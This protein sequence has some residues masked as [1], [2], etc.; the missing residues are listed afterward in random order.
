MIFSLSER[1]QAPHYLQK[2]SVSR[3]PWHAVTTS[4][5]FGFVA[6]ILE[7]LFPG[8]I[9]PALFQL[10]GS[11]ALVVWGTALVSQIVLRR[12]ADKAGVVLPVR[13]SGFPGL[14]IFALAILAAIFAVGFSAEQSRIQLIS[15][16]AV[17]AAIAGASTLFRKAR[18]RRPHP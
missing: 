7:L 14:T 5:V 15:S 18:L 8:R 17:I 12:R 1:G 9:L 6:A 4:V 2:R 13:M 11:T 3:V 16:A 10:I